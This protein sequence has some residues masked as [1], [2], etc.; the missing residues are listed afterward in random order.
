MRVDVPTLRCDRCEHT[1]QNLNEMARYA[2]LS[3]S[4]MG[5]TTDWDLCP[6]C[7]KEFN[8]FMAHVVR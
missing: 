2:K 6:D 7:W 1:T 3:H 8:S 5:G 4:N